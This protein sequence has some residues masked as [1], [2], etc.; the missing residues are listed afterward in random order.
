MDGRIA[1]LQVESAHFGLDVV[2]LRFLAHTVAQQFSRVASRIRRLG[3]VGAVASGN[4]R[5][6]ACRED[7]H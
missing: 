4:R 7:G 6:P 3:K 2:G 5:S 1:I